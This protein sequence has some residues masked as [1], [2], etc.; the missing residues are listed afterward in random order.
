[1]VFLTV[2]LS[3]G[4]FSSQTPADAF[5]G[6]CDAFFVPGVLLTCFSILSFCASNGLY[7]IFSYGVK[8]LKVLFTPFGKGKQQH[9]YEYKQEKE[10][11]RKK[12]HPRTLV[13]GLCYL[14]AAIVCLMLFNST[15]A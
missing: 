2:A 3:R 1:M 5:S 13:L 10:G 12:P 8:S 15:G 6:L 14:A 11:K 9:Y 4:V 7:D